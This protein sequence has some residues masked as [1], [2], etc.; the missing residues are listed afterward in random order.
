M[1]NRVSAIR[2]LK[3]GGFATAFIAVFIVVVILINLIAQTA[4]EKF[5]LF[6]DL[7]G[8]KAYELTETS[9]EYLETLQEAVS[10]QMMSDEATLEQN[11]GYYLQVRELLSQYEMHSDWVT[12]EYVDI[13]SNPGIVSQYP[14]LNLQRYDIL[15]KGEK[16]QIKI[17]FSSLFEKEY[18]QSTGKYYIQ[19]S[20]AEQELTS[21]IMRVVTDEEKKVLILRGQNQT[22]PEAFLNLLE[23]NGYEVVAQNLLTD[24][25]DMDATVAFIIAPQVDLEEDM[26]KKL[27]EYLT[28]DGN[29]GRCLIYAPHPTAGTLPNLDAF[30][31][32]WGIA[33]NTEIV[34]ENDP[35]RYVNNLPY[36]AL[37]TYTQ[38][39]YTENLNIDT[40][41]MS[42]L[43][44]NMSVL[45]E[46]KSVYTTSVLLS[47]S[48]QSYTINA[49]T[50]ADW[51]P[52]DEV[53]MERP[54][55][56]RSTYMTY[57]NTET[58]SSNL[59]V[60]AS[61]ASFDAS[62]LENSSTSN[63]QYILNILAK[64]TGRMDGMRIE[65]KT[66]SKAKLGITQQQYYI[67]SILF[68]VGM[69]L[70]MIAIGMIVWLKRRNR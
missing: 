66:L 65:P 67:Y 55:L 53:L 16:K 38:Q 57:D 51:M 70:I 47:Y 48:D 23:K 68:M 45:F 63:A 21:S 60:F 13:V 30:L 25:V 22:Y 6:L 1:K 19:Y 10:I 24:Q 33:M 12:V 2:K 46:N 37:T 56:V 26:I 54:A 4:A 11:G 29:Y 39:D 32:Q 64:V 40:P 42:P 3:Y 14:E 35:A 18:S 17:E 9:V 20:N 34:M 5:P 58:L 36:I 50:S 62:A 27:D 41:Y 43:G 49:K 52:T 15:V 44:R 31:A 59:F 8:N 28:N 69:P 61:A 7:T